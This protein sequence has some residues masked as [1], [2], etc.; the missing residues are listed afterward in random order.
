M[1][2]V[3]E[4]E[5]M[6]IN[7]P[8]KENFKMTTRYQTSVQEKGNASVQTENTG[9]KSYL[10]WQSNQCLFEHLRP[11]PCRHMNKLPGFSVSVRGAR[12]LSQQSKT[13]S[14]LLASDFP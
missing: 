1:K 3:S 6:G 13:I 5:P 12:G 4:E 14:A 11:A 2:A 7:I 9:K 8:D 10:K